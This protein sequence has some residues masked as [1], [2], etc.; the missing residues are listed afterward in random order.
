MSELAGAT[1]GGV[2]DDGAVM[3]QG[4]IRCSVEYTALFET[5]YL[6]WV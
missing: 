5:W 3:V 6:A 2:G 4:L 1:R